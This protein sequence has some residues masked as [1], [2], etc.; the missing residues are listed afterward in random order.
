[1]DVSYELT[2]SSHFPNQTLSVF[3]CKVWHNMAN[4]MDMNNSRAPK[5]KPSNIAKQI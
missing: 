2:V 5:R 1:M 3:I 4:H